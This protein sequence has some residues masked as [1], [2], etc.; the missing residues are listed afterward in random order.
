VLAIPHQ[1]GDKKVV[2]ASV[3]IAMTSR[4]DPISP[5]DLLHRADEALYTA[6]HAG[7]DRVTGWR[8]P[9]PIGVRA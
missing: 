2:T 3:G 5:A 7:R 6:K 1:G 4:D 9:R 8:R